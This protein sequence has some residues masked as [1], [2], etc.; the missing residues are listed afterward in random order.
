MLEEFFPIAG[1]APKS[2]DTLL[3]SDVLE[4]VT[5]E[6]CSQ[7]LDSYRPLVVPLGWVVFECPQEAGYNLNRIHTPEVILTAAGW[8]CQDK[9]L[10]N[11]RQ[12]PDP[13]NRCAGS[14][15]VCNQF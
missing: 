9:R 8:Q 4:H 12:N 6:G 10:T 2:F 5:F 13:F 1:S 7:F 11:M 14:A 15:F 3:Q